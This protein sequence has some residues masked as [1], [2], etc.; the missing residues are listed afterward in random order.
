MKYRFGRK[1]K[2]I[3]SEEIRSKMDFGKLTEQANGVS[4][5][6]ISSP[7]LNS[8]WKFSISTTVLST[9]AVILILI[10]AGPAILNSANNPF[11]RKDSPKPEPQVEQPA[12]ILDTLNTASLVEVEQDEPEEQVIFEAKPIQ[13]AQPKMLVEKPDTKE[14]PM[15][16]EDVLV[17]A[18]P[19][20]DLNSFL[21]A[22]DEELVYPEEAR[23]DSVEGFVRVYFK[24][25]KEGYPEDFK[26]NK[27]LGELFDNEA[28]RVL[29]QHKDWEPASFNGQAVDSY[30]TLKVSFEFKK[31]YPGD[32]IKYY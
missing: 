28:I 9:A 15:R 31:P 23:K 5:K 6:N 17:R 24:V 12:V 13:K 29:K 14:K 20:P 22:I 25:N 16:N 4:D 3:S 7:E 30:F 21:D 8:K 2:P 1:E 19:L 32:T 18:Y 11:I 10:T 27:S 26:V